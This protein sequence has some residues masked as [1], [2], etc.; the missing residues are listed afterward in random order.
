MR[1]AG[2]VLVVDDH[3]HLAENLAEI[4]EGG[5]HQVLVAHSAE[6]A[7]QILAQGDVVALITDYRLPGM[8]GAALI[9]ELRRQGSSI[10]AL[11]ISAFND[12]DTIAQARAAGA[13]EVLTKP[14]QID[15][16]LSLVADMGGG[17]RL[18][19]LA[20]D[21]RALAENLAEILQ[22]RGYR[23]QIKGSMAEAVACAPAPQAAILDY[24]LPDG[25]GIELA[26]RLTRAHPGVR[27]LFISGHSAELASGLSGRLAEAAR[28][29]K[30][31]DIARL[32]DW[33]NAA[34]GRGSAQAR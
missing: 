8:S 3:V 33:V 2:K 5:G 23:V 29:E 17:E 32:L 30:P 34:M 21:N 18:V 10:P 11:V 20:E 7:L 1:L 14:V 15:R 25:T 26:E 4:L 13:F 22:A 9:A 24:R 6:A 27:I 31:L 19:L 28:L 12:D 16:L